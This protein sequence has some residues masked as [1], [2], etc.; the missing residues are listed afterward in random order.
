[1]LVRLLD[2]QQQLTEFNI[3]ITLDKI[4]NKKIH[5]GQVLAALKL[6]FEIGFNNEYRT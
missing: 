3:W 4:S 1:M 2:L 6:L 5:T